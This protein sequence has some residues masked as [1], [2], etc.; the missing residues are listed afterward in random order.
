MDCTL[1]LFEAP[2]NCRKV[3][4]RWKDGVGA[5]DVKEI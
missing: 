3:V 1:K 4:H 5:P 2:R